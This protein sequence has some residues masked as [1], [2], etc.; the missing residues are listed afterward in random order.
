MWGRKVKRCAPRATYAAVHAFQGNGHVLSPPHKGAMR[1]SVLPL[2]AL[3]LLM[4]PAIA[5]AASGNWEDS[6]EEL[7]GPQTLTSQARRRCRLTSLRDR[8]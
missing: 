6:N 5:R 4:A 8:S 2:A 7:S 1:L 3:L